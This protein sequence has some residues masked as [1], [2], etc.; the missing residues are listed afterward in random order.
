MVVT[1]I[2]VTGPS[3]LTTRTLALGAMGKNM[4]WKDVWM[5]ETAS[6]LEGCV[7][8]HCIFLV[9]ARVPGAIGSSV[10]LAELA[11]T[12]RIKLHT[13]AVS[14]FVLALRVMEFLM[15]LDLLISFSG[16]HC[17]CGHTYSIH[18]KAALGRWGSAIS[19]RFTPR[20]GWV[21]KICP[22]QRTHEIKPS[23]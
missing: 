16:G 6:L 19:S 10:V 8:I 3:I 1:G 14:L 2:L 11:K 4:P 9:F 18:S 22:F 15:I 13:A 20:P 21:V 17:C 23:S 12:L 5:E 7:K